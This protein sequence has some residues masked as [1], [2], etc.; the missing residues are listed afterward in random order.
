MYIDISG[1]ECAFVCVRVAC[2]SSNV[3]Y[4]SI[5]LRETSGKKDMKQRELKRERY[6]K[7][8]FG[9]ELFHMLL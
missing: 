6:L 9:Y 5:D 4:Y 1:S 7:H 8:H 3:A 2:I